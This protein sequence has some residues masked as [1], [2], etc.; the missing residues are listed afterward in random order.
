MEQ[1]SEVKDLLKKK[2]NN[3]KTRTQNQTQTQRKK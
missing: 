2:I 3:K 1:A